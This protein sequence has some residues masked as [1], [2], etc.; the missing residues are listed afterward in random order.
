MKKQIFL[1]TI[2]CAMVL[3]A[4]AQTENTKVRT[5]D[6]VITLNPFDS[7]GCTNYSFETYQWLPYQID[8]EV[9]NA[10]EI[11]WTTSGDGT[12]DNASIA[13]PHYYF[14]KN[15]LLANA[16]VLTITATGNNT[17]VSND[18]ALGIPMQ[19]IPIT[20]D[21]WTGLSS[22]VDK[23]DTPVP[24]V[25][26][27]V[28]DQLIIMINKEGTS[29]WQDHNPPI[30]NL[31]NWSAIGYQGKFTNPPAC[32]PIYGSPL[33]DQSF[34]VEG[35][36]TYLPVFT[37]YPVLIEDLF[38]ENVENILEIF[39]WK[40]SLYWRPTQPDFEYLKPGLAYCLILQFGYQP[41]T[42]EF[43]PYSW[44]LPL[45]IQTPTVA[46]TSVFPNPSKG[47]FHVTINEPTQNTEYT[48]I[49]S[50]GAIVK[51]GITN[52]SFNIDISSQAKGLYYLKIA[53]D[54]GYSVK[55]L[56]LQ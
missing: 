30:N 10:D 3:S 17:T 16:V 40:D 32:L 47:I 56:I 43:P 49:N 4:N 35:S 27:P 46:E 12:F 6:P 50:Q 5:F 1:L 41:F 45:E 19:L 15:D 2:I 18:I 26:S 20:K 44:D 36:F 14:G 52:E 42:L 24:E 11:Q 34:F 8:A 22:Y 31:G 51:K 55:K 53:Y 9:Q 33:E 23:S 48:I 28:E 29:Y 38:D 13:A 37:D 7:L 21:G 25:M 39:D 54:D